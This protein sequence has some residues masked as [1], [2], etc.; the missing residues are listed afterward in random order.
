ML[1]EVIPNDDGTYEV[2]N[3][4]SN[5]RYR[6]VDMI[7]GILYEQSKGLPAEELQKI[8]GEQSLDSI[9]EVRHTIDLPEILNGRIVTVFVDAFDKKGDKVEGSSEA[10]YLRVR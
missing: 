8:P 10:F 1:S 7:E 4:I 3:R 2:G 6:F 9:F 5:I